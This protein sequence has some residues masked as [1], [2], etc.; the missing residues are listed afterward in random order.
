MSKP[1]RL[2]DLSPAQMAAVRDRVVA[3]M[4]AARQVRADF[5]AGA[6]FE[7]MLAAV[8]DCPL[9][10]AVDDEALAYFPEKTKASLGW[11]FATKEDIRHFI[12]I[13]ANPDADTVE[14]GSLTNDAE[15]TFDNCT[16]RHY[17]VNVWMMFGQGT[18]VSIFNDAQ[19]D[20]RQAS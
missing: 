15:C 2:Q 18:A 4:I 19:R 10:R 12:D 8:R 7:R 11:E 20:L 5:L 13:V 17:G 6:V 9:P 1:Q 14:P 16:F 3:S